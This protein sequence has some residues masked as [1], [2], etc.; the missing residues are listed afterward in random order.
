MHNTS[1]RKEYWATIFKYDSGEHVDIY[2]DNTEL[3]F[4]GDRQLLTL[5]FKIILNRVREKS[6]VDFTG[7]A[8]GPKDLTIP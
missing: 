4:K 3:S 5:G 1:V 8:E 6:T 7:H 2:A